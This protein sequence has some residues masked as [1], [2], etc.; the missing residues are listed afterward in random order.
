[1]W[2]FL[3][4]KH[5]IKLRLK[6]F[7]PYYCWIISQI[8]PLYPDKDISTYSSSI[9]MHH[10]KPVIHTNPESNFNYVN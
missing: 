7:L 8:V 5:M 1:M 2:I 9:L 3:I 10:I 4:I 6:D